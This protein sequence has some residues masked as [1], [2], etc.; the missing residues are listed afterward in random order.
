A[1]GGRGGEGA[2]RNPRRRDEG[3]RG[4]DQARQEA[5]RRGEGR[6]RRR[7]GGS[8]EARRS[9]P[10][11]VMAAIKEPQTSSAPHPPPSPQAMKRFLPAFAVFALVAAFAAA[12]DTRPAD[13]NQPT[14]PKTAGGAAQ[15]EPKANPWATTRSVSPAVLMSYEE[16][17]ELLEA[18]R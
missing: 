9:A 13:P 10:A 8:S 5:A 14:Q 17:L 6:G 2:T 1:T 15:P 4:Q 16:N 12:Q 3:G 11:A 18:Q 7:Q